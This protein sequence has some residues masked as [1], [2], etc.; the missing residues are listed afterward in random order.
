MVHLRFM[1]LRIIN[2]SCMFKFKILG[3]FTVALFA[4]NANAQ[5]TDVINSN[6][7]GESMS[8]FSVG[9]NVFQLETGIFGIREKHRLLGTES[10]GFGADLALRW[11]LFAEQ[12][13][14]VLDLQYQADS[15]KTSLATERRS[16]LRQTTIGAKYLIYDPYKN[17][18]E[19]VNI[20]S[21]KA[22]HKFKWRQLIPAIG[23]YA[24]ANLNFDNP[25]TFESDPNIS[26]KLMVITQNQLS[27]GFVIVGNI[28]ADK[29]TSDFPSYGYILTVTKGIN[30]Q[31]SAFIENQGI[32]SDYYADALMRGGAAYLLKENMQ[33]DASLAFNLKD[34]PSIFYGGVGFS[35]RFDKNYKPVLIR[36]GKDTK[37]DD[38]G[39]KGKKDKKNNPK[40]EESPAN[41]KP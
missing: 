29:I 34:T 11:G 10:A 18:E 15:Y 6:R 24:G 39:K 23:V 35:W 22:N 14:F 36:S 19:K 32:K 1:R 40:I 16:A 20:Y 13:E 8:G 38:K 30:E 2:H 3:F 41:T 17:Y 37:K 12:L 27:G 25:Y 9:E 4:V 26:P 33:V 7:P 28:I 31:W 21:W 5:Y